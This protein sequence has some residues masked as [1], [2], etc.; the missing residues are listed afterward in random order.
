MFPTGNPERVKDGFLS[1]SLV[2]EG[3]NHNVPQPFPAL[4]G[5]DQ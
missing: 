3:V 4:P 1:Y 5:R 2:F